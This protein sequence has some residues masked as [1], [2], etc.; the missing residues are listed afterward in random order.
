MNEEML[1][2]IFSQ[3]VPTR[4]GFPG[5]DDCCASSYCPQVMQEASIKLVN[6]QFHGC[7]LP[8]ISKYPVILD[9]DPFVNTTAWIA[10]LVVVHT[11][12]NHFYF[13]EPLDRKECL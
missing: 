1:P 11:S 5:N 7:D 12:S 2:R 9:A 4:E 8:N 6:L 3:C 13:I 10:C